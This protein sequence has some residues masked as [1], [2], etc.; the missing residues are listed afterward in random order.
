M[1]RLDVAYATNT[2]RSKFESEYNRINGE[3]EVNDPH[4]Q[5][6]ILRVDKRVWHQR[7]ISHHPDPVL[8]QEIKDTATRYDTQQPRREVSVRSVEAWISLWLKNQYR[9]SGIEFADSNN[10]RI[11][12]TSFAEFGM[13]SSLSV[14]FVNDLN[15]EY[16]LK[17]EPSILW[18]YSTPKQLAKYLY[19]HELQQV[20]DCPLGQSSG[21][22]DESQEEILKNMIRKELS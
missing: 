9:N 6:T 11:A 19:D 3:H 7:E 16:K 18:S 15:K 14:Q 13:D 5:D 2:S 12:T 10:S 4:Q 22:I 8:I 20:Q 1:E 21:L 17:L